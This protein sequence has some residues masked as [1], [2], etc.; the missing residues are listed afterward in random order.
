[1]T[2]LLRLCKKIIL[3]FIAGLIIAFA[4]ANQNTVSLSFQPLS[5]QFLLPLYIPV[6]AALFLGAIIGGLFVAAR[7]IPLRSSLY[8]TKRELH[9]TKE[10]LSDLEKNI[11]LPAEHIPLAS[12]TQELATTTKNTST[13]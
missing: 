3:L 9:K 11:N 4:L 7:Y 6:L 2:F 1:M 12:E 8:S 10:K 13:Q 5:F